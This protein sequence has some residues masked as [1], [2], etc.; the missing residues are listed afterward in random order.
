MNNNKV[1][2]I[3]HFPDISRYTRWINQME[4]NERLMPPERRIYKW[5]IVM[6]ML[7]ILFLCSFFFFPG[8][9]INYQSVNPLPL[10][11]SAGGDTLKKKMSVTFDMPVDSFE[12]HLKKEIHEKLSH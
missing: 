7:F 6:T 5:M 10:T 3:P 4:E 1:P 12:K 2:N 8:P 9:G 11:D